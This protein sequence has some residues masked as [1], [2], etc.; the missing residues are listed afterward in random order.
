MNNWK[1]IVGMLLGSMV[2]IGLMAF[3]LSKVSDDS[4]TLK[5]AN[6]EL[7][8][9]G[10]FVIDNG[11]KVTVVEFSDVQCPAC[12]AA[13]PVAKQLRQM[14]GVKYVY[15]DFP[16]IN[17]H[18]NAWKGARAVEAARLMGRGFEMLELMFDKQEE[19]SASP[20]FE[21]LVVSY[22]KQLG[23]DENQFITIWNSEETDKLVNIDFMEANKLKL[24]G[25]PTFFVN[26]EQVATDFVLS[27]VKDL[28]K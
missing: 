25:T 4:K 10:R 7:V 11:N 22:A 9:G 21:D 23:L 26:G 13:E 15:R 8:S 6:E 20:K 1:A 17:I 16:L 3:G 18:Q 19:W 24:Q 14:D 12:K 27:K 28:L 5:V 2:I